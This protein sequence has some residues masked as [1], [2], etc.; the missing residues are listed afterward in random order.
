MLSLD[1]LHESEQTEAG[2]K[3]KVKAQIAV[4]AAG[5][6]AKAIDTV[7]L[8]QVV[9]LSGFLTEKRKDSK[10]LT[11]HLNEFKVLGV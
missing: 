4:V 10:S 7:L 3:R 11:L 6:I 2:V 9:R 1:F 5:E 8:G